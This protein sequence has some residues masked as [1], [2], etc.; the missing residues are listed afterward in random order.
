MTR[1]LDVL[2]LAGAVDDRGVL[3]LDRDALGAAQHAELDV[4]EL[5][6]EVLGDHLAVGQHGDVLEHGLAAVAEAGSLDGAHLEAAAQAVDDER[7]ECLALDVLGD[8]QQR[9]AGLDDGLEHRQH[10]LQAGQLLLVDEDVGV[11]E[12]GDHLVG[13]GDEV[14]RQVATVELHAL[15]DV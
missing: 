13:V 7:G 14:R 3:L 11:L 8:D 4:L 15:D 12:L 6:A 1:R 2:L 5:D 9:L 10:G